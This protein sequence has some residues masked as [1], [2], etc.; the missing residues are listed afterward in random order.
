M[1]LRRA[2]GPS[3]QQGKQKSRQNATKHGIFAVGIIR[4]RES[5]AEYLNAV[6]GMVEAL[7]PVGELE[8]ILVEKLAMLVWRYRRRLEAEAAEVEGQTKDCE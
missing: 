4:K 8:D 6:E 2:T 7:Q 1:S 5:E 3:T